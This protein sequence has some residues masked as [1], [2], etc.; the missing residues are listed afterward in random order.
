MQAAPEQAAWLHAKKGCGV[1]RL[2]YARS[3]TSPVNGL[4]LKKEGLCQRYR[5]LAGPL[6]PTPS[7]LHAKTLPALPTRSS[8]GGPRSPGPM[9]LPAEPIFAGGRRT[10]QTIKLD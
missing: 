6:P 8:V 9:H 7:P 1:T 4:P 2:D 3:E 10:A 5:R